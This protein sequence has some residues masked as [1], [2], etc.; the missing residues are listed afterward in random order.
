METVKINS[1]GLLLIKSFEG[2]ILH[3]YNDGYGTLTI[4]WGHT[5]DV[6][7]GQYITQAEADALLSK[8]LE[9]YEANVNK[10]VSRYNFNTN[11]FSALVSFAYNI[12]SIDE[13]VHEGACSIKEIEERIP[14]YCHAG[15]EVVEGLQR[16]RTEELK[17][18]KTPVEGTVKRDIPYYF[19]KVA[20]TLLGKY[21]TD[22]ERKKALGSDYD[23]VQDSINVLYKYLKEVVE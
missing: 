18:F 23:I 12:G 22:Q 21:G 1:K 4:G 9:R 6:Y 16:R 3:A 13:L 20:N 15:G 2:C 8:D 17:L 11:Q 10:Y 19:D 14:L 5:G 7:E